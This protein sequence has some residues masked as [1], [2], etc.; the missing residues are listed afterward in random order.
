VGH[1]LGSSKRTRLSNGEDRRSRLGKGVE[2]ETEQYNGE[3]RFRAS[4]SIGL[5][6]LYNTRPIHLYSGSTLSQYDAC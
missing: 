4:S 5:F 2:D 3:D 6:F 1:S